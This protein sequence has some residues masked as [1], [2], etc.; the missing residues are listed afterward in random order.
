MRY[1]YVS[2]FYI[3]DKQLKELERKRR[4]KNYPYYNPV[5]FCYV[6]DENIVKQSIMYRDFL[7]KSFEKLQQ[8]DEAFREMVSYEL[9]N[10]EAC[11]TN[12]V[13]DGLSALGMRYEDLTEERQKIVREE[14]KKQIDYYN[15]D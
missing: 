7:E 8:S 1:D 6:A 10:H 9:A 3:G 11:I 4:K 12:D 14:L 5:S 2:A 13:T 15:A